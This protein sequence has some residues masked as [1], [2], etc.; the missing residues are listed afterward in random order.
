MR[1][2]P[3]PLIW[4]AHLSANVRVQLPVLDLAKILVRVILGK[5]D[6]NIPEILLFPQQFVLPLGNPPGKEP[7][8]DFLFHGE[9][10]ILVAALY[11]AMLGIE[12]GIA[13]ELPC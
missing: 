13:L 7:S 5:G 12:T 9:N 11:I 3:E 1:A 10:K 2:A 8:L 6:D 4:A